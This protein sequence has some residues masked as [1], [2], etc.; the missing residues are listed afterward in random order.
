VGQFA[1][2]S[3]AKAL[4]TASYTV[5][6]TGTA[7]L[8]VSEFYHVTGIL[9]RAVTAAISLFWAIGIVLLVWSLV[10]ENKNASDRA[11]LLGEA[12]KEAASNQ[13]TPPFITDPP[14]KRE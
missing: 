3:L 7:V 4:V 13:S 11:T 2:D 1:A 6:A 9:A 14:A 8:G 10:R 5:L 12:A